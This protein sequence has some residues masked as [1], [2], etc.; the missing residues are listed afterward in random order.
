MTERVAVY[1]GSFDPV[2]LGHL[3]IIRRAKLAVDQLIVAVVRNPGKSPMFTAEERVEMLG[4]CLG[5]CEGLT[6]VSFEGLL[7]DFVRAQGA[8][9]IVRGLRAVSD[10]DYEF[11]MAVQNRNLAAEVDTL[12][13]MTDER[14]FYVSSR[15]VKEIAMLDGTVSHMVPETVER[16]LD[17]K[18]G[19]A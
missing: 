19:K 10:F 3:N 8:H 9:F 18:R 11:Q 1:P 17:K 5:D 16:L 6:I 14:Y 2:T 4:E 13:M 7:I 15:M 12:F